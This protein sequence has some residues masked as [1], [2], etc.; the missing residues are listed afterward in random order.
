MGDK[1][2]DR[3]RDIV[4]GHEKKLREQM[5]IKVLDERSKRAACPILIGHRVL[6]ELL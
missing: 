1:V 2:G 5:Q 4:V 3:G 6:R